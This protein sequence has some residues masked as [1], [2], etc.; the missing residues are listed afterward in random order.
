M[1]GG[2]RAALRWGLRYGLRREARIRQVAESERLL[3]QKQ[4]GLRLV[5]LNTILTPYG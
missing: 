3:N 2:D 4:L 5:I 1:P